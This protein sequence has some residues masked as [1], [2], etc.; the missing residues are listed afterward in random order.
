MLETWLWGDGDGKVMVRLMTTMLWWW[1]SKRKSYDE[2]LQFPPRRCW[3]RSCCNT[4][5]RCQRWRSTSTRTAPTT[6]PVLISQPMYKSFHYFNDI[7]TYKKLM[8][9]CFDHRWTWSTTRDCLLCR[10]GGSLERAA[11]DRYFFWEK[12]RWQC[13]WWWGWWWWHW[14]IIEIWQ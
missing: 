13:W 9:F 2:R 8:D 4:V 10:A 1:W 3:V 14:V 11:K 7:C 12:K 5:G 6:A